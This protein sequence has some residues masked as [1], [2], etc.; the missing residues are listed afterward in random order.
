MKFDVILQCRSNSKR[1]PNKIFYKINDLTIL[2]ILILNLKKIKYLNRIILA[3]SFREDVKK[4][5]EITKKHNVNLFVNSKG[6]SENNVLSRFFN[7]SKKYNSKN[8]IR[9]TPDCPFINIHIIKKMM[10]YYKKKKLKFLTNNKPRKVPHGFDCE[11]FSFE[12][13][14]HI[15]ENA[16]TPENL[17]HVTMWIYK[18]N[19]NFVKNYSIYHKDYSKIRI[20]L[21]YK[22]DFNFFVKNFSLLKKIS[23]LKNPQHLL[24]TL[25]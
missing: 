18:N 6:I 3:I 8:I 9:I 17:E 19:P 15:Y 5:H 25:L 23:N 13:L 4:F 22:N 24:K 1:L 21:D 14:R 16:K 12:T 2:E 10:M 20:T 7:C 11:I